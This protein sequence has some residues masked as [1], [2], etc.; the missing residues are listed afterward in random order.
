MVVRMSL[1]AFL[2]PLTLP[3]DDTA[4]DPRGV[5]AGWT[6]L[7][8][9]LLLCALVT[10]IALLLRKELRRVDAMDLPSMHDAEVDTDA[11]TDAEA[12]HT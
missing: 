7:A 2:T 8:V 9:V 12:S 4:P 5:T 6:G 11:D 3:F 1:L 10:G